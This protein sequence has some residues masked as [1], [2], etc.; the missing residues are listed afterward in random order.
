MSITKH[1]E[2]TFYLCYEDLGLSKKL[3][4]KDILLDD[5]IF[6]RISES[7]LTF[8]Y[9]NSSDQIIIPGVYLNLF[10]SIDRLLGDELLRPETT[11]ENFLCNGV[12]F[13][14]MIYGATGN[15]R[16]ILSTSVSLG[17]KDLR[18]L[19]KTKFDYTL[20]PWTLRNITNSIEI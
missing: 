8:H 20:E 2:E 16:K 11:L 15:I 10:M 4:P 3:K 7:K 19:L 1:F 17:T 12:K 6:L 5:F 13:S 9:L 14:R 18:V